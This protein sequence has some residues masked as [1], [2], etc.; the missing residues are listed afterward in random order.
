MCVYN[1]YNVNLGVLQKRFQ[2]TARVHNELKKDSL[3]IT[4]FSSKSDNAVLGCSISLK[5]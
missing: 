4:F 1:K 5:R 2:Y 3:T